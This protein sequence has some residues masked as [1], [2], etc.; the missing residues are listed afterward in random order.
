MSE[1]QDTVK[2]DGPRSKVMGILSIVLASIGTFVPVVG[3]YLTIVAG[4]L[5]A[6]SY[7]K[8]AF[9]GYIGIGINFVSLCFLSPLLWVAAS[10]SDTASD[11]VGGLVWFLIGTQAVCLV[12]AI[13]MSRRANKK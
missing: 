6:L 5:A 2:I 11:S 4:L 9:L 10:S 1:N 3:V 7:G 13:L 8:S 12:F